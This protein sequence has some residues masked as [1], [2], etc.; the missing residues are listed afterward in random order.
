MISRKSLPAHQLKAMSM[1]E[2]VVVL[3]ITLLLGMFIVSSVTRA[4]QRTKAVVNQNNLREIGMAYLTYAADNDGYTPQARRHETGLVGPW[5]GSA[6]AWSAPARKLF[7]RTD[8]RWGVNAEGTYNYLNS[9]DYLYSPFDKRNQNRPAGQFSTTGFGY[10][11]MYSPRIQ[12]LIPNF[13][14]EKITDEPNMPLC[15][16]FFGPSYS[17]ETFTSEQCAVLYLDGMVSVFQQ[18][19]LSPE[20]RGF[21]QR[22]QY[23]INNR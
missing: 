15:A 13:Y 14:N 6:N 3:T 18:S 1:I 7:D 4:T 11:F 19:D 21:N 12:P 2:L 23:L 17:P 10:L 20:V 8:A 16:D 5:F 9:P 22:F